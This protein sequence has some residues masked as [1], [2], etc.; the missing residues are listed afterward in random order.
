MTITNTKR[1]NPWL[2]EPD[3][4]F[5][6]PQKLLFALSPKTEVK[7]EFFSKN[8][9]HLPPSYL[10]GKNVGDSKVFLPNSCKYQDTEYSELNKSINRNALGKRLLDLPKKSRRRKSGQIANLNCGS[11]HRTEQA[12]I[13]KTFLRLA[14]QWR[15]DTRGVSSTNELSMHPAYQQIIGMGD[16]VVPLLL[17]E[18]ERK[19]GQWFWA[20][21]AITREDPVPLESKGRT[22]EMIKFWLEWG[23]EKGYR[24]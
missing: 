22:K 3:K 1:A 11:T 5:G 12:E 4:C 7:R 19:S 8:S 6:Y 10:S 16:A 9:Y 15:R 13:E 24:W 23:R 14:D 18:L 21:K 20:L 2:Q 17:R